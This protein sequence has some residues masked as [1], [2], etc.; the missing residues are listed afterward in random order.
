[1]E[2]TLA[3]AALLVLVL[4]GAALADPPA[5]GEKA[6]GPTATL[7]GCLEKAKEPDTFLLTNAEEAGKKVGKVELVGAPSSLGLAGH[8]GHKV[9]IEGLFLG[10]EASEKAASGETAAKQATTEG[11]QKERHLE[12]KSMKHLAA[13]CS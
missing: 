12:V 7:T 9:Q 13:S 3:S 5:A 2:K 10:S 8:V 11:G 6:A 4:G 1:M